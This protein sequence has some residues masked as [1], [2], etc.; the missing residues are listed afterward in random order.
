MNMS[1]LH[2][3]LRGEIMAIWQGKSLRKPS[4]ARAK[5][6]RNKRNMEF[7]R[8]PA[9]TKIGDRKTKIIRTKGGNEK[10]RLANDKNINVVDPKTNKVQ[11]AEIMTVVENTA[12]THFV[13]RNIITKGAVVDTSL[14]KV[15]VTSRPGQHGMINGVLVE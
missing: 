15:K 1:K 6:N 13:R 8:D 3:K 4:G 9:D 11:V 10:I 12:N 7:G 14:G 2:F 5:T